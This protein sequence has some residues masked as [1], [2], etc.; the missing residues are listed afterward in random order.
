MA[1]NYC[2]VCEH[3]VYCLSEPCN[4][5]E[6]C[7][8]EDNICWSCEN[9]PNPTT[10]S[11]TLNSN[12]KKQP[13]NYCVSCKHNTYCLSEPC[14]GCEGCVNEDNICW[15]CE[16]NPNPTTNSVTLNIIIHNPNHYIE[17]STKNTQTGE[18]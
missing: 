8:N 14:N 11:L 17:T 6:G 13:C 9:N 1:C 3:Y 7:V 5:C 16:N 4:G 12:H 18:N 2:Y 10:N 15:N